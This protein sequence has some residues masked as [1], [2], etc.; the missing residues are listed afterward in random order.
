MSEVKMPTWLKTQLKNIDSLYQTN[1]PEWLKHHFDES[2]T[3]EQTTLFVREYG[4]ESRKITKKPS[5]GS[6]LVKT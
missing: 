5:A 3:N 2:T 1:V 6:S 4:I